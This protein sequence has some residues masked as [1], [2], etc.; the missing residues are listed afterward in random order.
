MNNGLLKVCL[1]EIPVVIAQ[2]EKNARAHLAQLLTAEAEGAKLCLFPELSLTGYTCADLFLTHGLLRAADEALALLLRESAKL[3]VIGIAGIPVLF[4]GALYNCAAVFLRGKLLGVVPKT[5]LPNYGEYYETRY[6]T[7]GHAVPESASVILAGQEAPFGTSL[8]F[9]C[10]EFPEF[11][12]AVEICEDLWAPVSPSA[13]HALAGANLICNLS[14]SNEFA[15]K[16]VVRRTLLAAQSEK[17]L[18]AYLYASGSEGESSTD[19]A[20]SSVKAVSTLGSILEHNGEKLY[21]TVDLQSVAAARRRS[22]TFHTGASRSYC[23][24]IPFSLTPWEAPM[25]RYPKAPFLHGMARETFLDE[26]FDLQVKGLLRR[27]RAARAK[28]LVLG[29]SGGVDS[30]LA[31]LVCAEAAKRAERPEMICAVLMPGF[32]TTERSL[33]SGRALVH[34]MEL[35]PLVLDIRALSQAQLDAI[36]HDG[37]ADTTYENT[38]ARQRTMMLMNLANEC[39]GIVVGTSDLSE[40]AIGFST[41]GGDH[42]SM[43]NVNGSVPK[44]IARELLLHR[45]AQ[46]SDTLAAEL[47]AVVKAPVS[48]ELLPVDASGAQKQETESI[49]GSYSLIDFLLYYHLKYGFTQE[50][51]TAMAKASFAEEF[52]PEEIERTAEGYF[53]RFYRSQFKRSCMPDGVKAM[54]L[55]LSPR[56]DFRLP[57]DL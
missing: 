54:E 50:K 7:S 46:S 2:P 43:Y 14:A 4:R 18:C 51:L 24:A 41:Y 21:E 22:T 34:A 23:R 37:S 1:T 36:G 30:T 29:V 10:R 56:S 19:L 52:P 25:K 55:S 28:A 15:G 20:F 9:T 6:F 44:T 5:H 45:A 57:S 49:V 3:D 48:P 42:M 47:R 17:L 53:T 26:V 31:L 27:L 35:E 16:G 38:Q 8:Q 11:T 33:Q 39:G 13:G 32:G 40:I 12:F